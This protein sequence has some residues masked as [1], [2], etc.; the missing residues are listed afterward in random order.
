MDGRNEPG[1]ARAFT[2]VE[3]VTVMGILAI[4]V[5]LIVGAGGAVSD[6][7]ARKAT[8]RL[9]ASLDAAL[10]GYYDDWGKFP[11]YRSE[12]DPD[13]AELLGKVSGAGIT[14]AERRAKPS[15]CPIPVPGQY[16][17]NVE[18]ML[19]A[20]LNMR[21]RNGPYMHAGNENVRLFP[22]GTR[23]DFRVYVDAW[24]R[25]IHYFPP[26]TD[27][28][29]N[30]QPTPL[31]M[32]EGRTADIF[33]HVTQSGDMWPNRSKADNL[34]NYDLHALGVTRIDAGDRKY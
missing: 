21:E 22:Y 13:L 7:A 31:L 34:A 6:I 29:G 28:S 8:E 25:P 9:L 30:L 19:Y 17:N 11:W 16:E 20:T 3:L 5:A 26:Q 33:S 12:S 27:S 23:M 18:A 2:L 32:S 24:G 15:Y 1:G 4:L 10:Q 14:L